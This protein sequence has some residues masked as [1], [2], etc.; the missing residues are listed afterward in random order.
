MVNLVARENFGKVLA[1]NFAQRA[2]ESD[3]GA[4]SPAA[5]MFPSSPSET[6]SSDALR[7]KPC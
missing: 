6:V 2:P 1:L 5:E 4:N 3:V 7:R